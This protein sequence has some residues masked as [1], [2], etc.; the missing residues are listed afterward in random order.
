MPRVIY[1]NMSADDTE[2][3]RKFYADVF[4]WAFEKWDGPMEYWLI[5][6]G[7]DKQPGINGGLAKRSALNPSVVNLISVP[8]IEEYSKKITEM[9]GTVSPGM[10]I[11]GV[12]Y[13]AH[14]TDS[15][16]NRFDILEPEQNAK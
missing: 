4:G 8:S 3:A 6:T 12:G 5:K 7:D 11:K 16:G 10:P 14:C 9:G 15:E 2:R 1:F 13:F